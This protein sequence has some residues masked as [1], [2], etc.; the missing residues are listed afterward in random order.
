MELTVDGVDHVAPNNTR[1]GR[2]AH[3]YLLRKGCQEV[4]FLTSSPEWGLMRLRGQSFLNASCDAGRPGTAYLP[5]RQESGCASHVTEAYGKRVVVAPTL[6]QLTERLA[7]AVRTRQ[8]GQHPL[9][10]FCG[11]DAMTV[12]IFP[13][14]SRLGVE[15]G[16]DLVI[17]SCDNEAIRLAGLSPRPT[18][19]DIGAEEIGRRAVIRLGVRIQRPDEPTFSIHVSP[20]LVEPH[21]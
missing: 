4:A 11:N 9:G 17:V 5:E 7:A 1:I 3:D 20:R 19:I 2:I 6:E 12:A 10:L 21:E 16:R 15:V 13:L 8:A 18:S 14:L